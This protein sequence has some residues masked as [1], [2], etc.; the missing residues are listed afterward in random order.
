MQETLSF[1]DRDEFQ[2]KSIA[3]NIVKLL[4][5]ETDISP[6]VIDGDWGTGK[7]EFSI[8]L[9][10]LILEQEGNGANLLI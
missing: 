7:T 5:P 9:K 1:S 6:L 4:I 2:R 3:E 8:K 10:N